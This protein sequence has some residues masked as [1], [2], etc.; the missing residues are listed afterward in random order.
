[1][2]DVFLEVDS[3]LG[4]RL[5][6]PDLKKCL[7]RE[8]LAAQE[9]NRCKSCLG[10]LRYL[11]RNSKSAAH[12]PKVAEL[13]QL[14]RLSPTQQSH[15]ADSDRTDAEIPAG[16]ARRGG[17][18]EVGASSDEAVGDGSE[19]EGGDHEGEISGVSCS[20][21]PSEDDGDLV[22]EPLK[23]E[24]EVEVS[25]GD[26]H[27]GEA[28]PNSPINPNDDEEFPDSQVS[29]NWLGKAYRD[30]KL[31]EAYHREPRFPESTKEQSD[32]D[33]VL[34]SRTLQLG[35]NVSDGSGNDDS[36]DDHDGSVP[37]NG[38]SGCSNILDDIKKELHSDGQLAEY[39]VSILAPFAPSFFP[40]LVPFNKSID[41]VCF[42]SRFQAPYA[43][44][45]LQALPKGFG[46]LWG[47]SLQ[48]ALLT[49]PLPV[50][51]SV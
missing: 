19:S 47:F 38:L 40:Y 10:S 29:S 16:L 11:W 26:S 14:V 27:T 6:R 13:K 45:V 17:G 36:D 44:G 31:Y 32:N 2:C 20:Y 12:H 15:L 43:G 35:D 39:L 30:Q 7:S 49:K 23:D 24:A 4:C 37:V 21:V 46:G 5:F 18:S 48:R 34:S 25:S 41:F 22:G 3:I 8:T 42:Y 51:G 50:L 33:D 1:M 9:A 28:A